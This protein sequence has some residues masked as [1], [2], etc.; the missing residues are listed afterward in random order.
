MLRNNSSTYY[1]NDSLIIML[2]KKDEISFVYE[3]CESDFS[4]EKFADEK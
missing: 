3:V 2:V 1:N 4:S